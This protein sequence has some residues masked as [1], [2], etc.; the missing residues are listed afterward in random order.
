MLCTTLRA[1]MLYTQA[2]DRPE[3]PRRGRGHARVRT[4]P[5]HTTQDR[6]RASGSRLRIKRARAPLSTKRSEP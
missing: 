4:H 2:C 1:A 5:K 6:T 3:R